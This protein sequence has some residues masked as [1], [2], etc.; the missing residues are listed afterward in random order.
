MEFAAFTPPAPAYVGTSPSHKLASRPFHELSLDIQAFPQVRYRR[1]DTATSATPLDDD[2][3][4]AG[5]WIDAWAPGGRRFSHWLF[6]VWPKLE[7]MKR[8]GVLDGAGVIANDCGAQLRGETLAALGVEPGRVR[9]VD[10]DGVE[11]E[12]GR[13]LRIGPLREVL[14]TPPWIIEAVRSAFLPAGSPAQGGRRLY[15]TR[16]GASRRRVVN[17]AALLEL[18]RGRGYEPVALETL[19]LKEAAALMSEAEAVLAPHGAGLANIVFCPP[20]CRVVE[21]FSLH[22]SP[23]YWLLAARMGLDYAIVECAA[24]DGRYLH[25]LARAEASDRAACNPVDIVADLA[26]IG[27]VI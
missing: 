16:A 27:S 4:G 17:E 9:L 18:A 24:P 22:I 1:S 21:F 7:A 15:V 3:A 8:L 14:Y 6:D 20:G 11:V 12:A 26:R 5:V 19:S 25:Q 10:R 13:A 2:V 23:E